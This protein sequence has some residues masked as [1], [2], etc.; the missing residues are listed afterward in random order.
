MTPSRTPHWDG[1]TDHGGRTI[2]RAHT[3]MAAACPPSLMV[4]SGTL[5]HASPHSGVFARVD[6]RLRH[7]DYQA[8]RSTRLA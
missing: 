8:V 7:P 4:E 2:E 3:W 1:Q 6:P 5:R